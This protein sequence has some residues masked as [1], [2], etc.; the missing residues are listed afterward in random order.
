MQGSR[1]SDKRLMFNIF[2]FVLP[3]VIL[4]ITWDFHDIRTTTSLVPNSVRLH[5]VYSRYDLL[6]HPS[7]RLGCTMEPL[8]KG[9]LGTKSF[10]S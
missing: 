7:D 2:I 1:L 4:L 6:W 5:E 3:V 8:N 9:R 10:C